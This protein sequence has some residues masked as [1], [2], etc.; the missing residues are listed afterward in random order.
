M[1]CDNPP[2]QED[3]IPICQKGLI[4]TVK[5]KLLGANIKS[6]DQLNSIV[7]DIEMF[8][9]EQMTQTSHKGKLPKERNKLAKEVNIIDSSPDDEAKGATISPAPKK[10]S[11]AKAPLPSLMGR[12][13]TPYSFKKQEAY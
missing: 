2:V 13:K 1:K 4:S 7:A 10:K 11:E 9:A 3:T 8:L 12:M 6:F 5:E